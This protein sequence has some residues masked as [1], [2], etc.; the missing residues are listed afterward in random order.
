MKKNSLF[1]KILLLMILS[2]IC[3]AITVFVSLLAGASGAELFNFQNLNLSNMIPVFIV[4]GIIS[5]FIIS[6][7]VLFVCRTVFL[8]VKDYFSETDKNN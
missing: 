8:K 7:A 1:G 2:F 5:C 3:I 4:G 6:I